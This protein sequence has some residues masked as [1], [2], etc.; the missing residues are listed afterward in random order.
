MKKTKL[1][2]LLLIC[3]SIISFSQSVT[4]SPNA[5]G[6]GNLQ[7]KSGGFTYGNISTTEFGGADLFFR[8]SE[9]GSGSSGS[10]KGVISTFHDRFQVK[11]APGIA[12][13]LGANNIE[14][15]RIT[16]AGFVGI[17]TSYPITKLE[18]NGFTKLGSEVDVPA[19]K[20]KK[21]PG[22]F[23][24]NGCV[25][26]THNLVQ[27]KILSVEVLVTAVTGNYVHAA[28][29]TPYNFNYYVSPTEIV[30]CG[31]TTFSSGLS[32]AL[33]ATKILI[34]FEE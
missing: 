18:V 28:Y 5:A 17:G 3:N 33:D 13:S 9:T 29:P 25:N 6:N 32:T 26:F 24:T 16:N 7:V 10:I 12:F 34:T 19:I 31:T 11:G 2:S 15:L 30:V 27:S 14:Q 23:N 1:L 22:N 21:I 8:T 4:I 20:I